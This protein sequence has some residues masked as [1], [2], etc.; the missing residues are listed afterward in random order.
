MPMR[1][2]VVGT[3][4][5][6]RSWCRGTLPR[7]VREGLIQVV[8]AV[9]IAPENLA[10][11]KEF[12][13]LKDEQCFTDAKNAFQSV[14]A[15]ACVIAAPP[16]AHEQLAALAFEHG[17]DV[18]S[19]K[20][21]ADTME[22][23]I[24]IAEKAKAAGRKM[25][26]TMSHKYRQ[27]IWTLRDMLRSGEYGK[28]DYL[29]CTIALRRPD[30]I[31]PRRNDTAYTILLEGSVHHLDILENL[32]GAECEY[33]HAEAWSPE[34]G[35]FKKGGQALVTM[36]FKNGVRA[37]YEAGFCN[38]T[39]QNKWGNEYLRA[40][41]EKGTIVMNKGGVQLFQP[42]ENKGEDG[43]YE[44]ITTDVSLRENPK[45]ANAYLLEQFVHWVN[46]GKKMETRIEENLRSMILV[47]AA[48]K[49][50]ETGQRVYIDEFMKSYGL[51]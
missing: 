40:E 32:A 35:P 48:V 10:N 5:W 13:E 31:R 50:S 42:S 37:G 34:W 9:D 2:I 8:A 4:G 27:D 51:K 25:G 21:I 19:E 39:T 17:L 24:R 36:R 12:L 22:S 3:G 18:L 6:G 23:S 38:A 28:L 16:E 14:K 30:S 46:G 44:T 26:I 47:F 43:L 33:L 11:A 15:E 20:P 1:V 29:V 7:A 45:W 49:S 41:C